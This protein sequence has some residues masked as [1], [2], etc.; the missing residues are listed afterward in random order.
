MAYDNS[1]KTKLLGVDA[2]DLDKHGAVSEEVVLQ[3]ASGIR[4]QTGADI[5]LSTSGIAGPDGGTDEKPV[6]TIWIGL[7]M[8]KKDRAIRLK[9]GR[10]RKLN[11]SLTVDH[12]LSI[13][14]KELVQSVE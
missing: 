6:G 1:V 9:L 8:G 4:R 11:I 7:S 10:N 2:S 5:G 14:I 13:L 3:M 12:L